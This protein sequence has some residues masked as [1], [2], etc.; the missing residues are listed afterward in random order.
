MPEDHPGTG[1]EQELQNFQE[2]M[3]KLLPQTSSIIRRLVQND[4]IDGY[5]HIIRVEAP[6]SVAV[7]LT[8]YVIV[9][10]ED[11]SAGRHTMTSS[12]RSRH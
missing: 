5:H 8:K 9:V 10:M 11:P 2:D 1:V 12:R 3:A 4:I 6:I 7:D